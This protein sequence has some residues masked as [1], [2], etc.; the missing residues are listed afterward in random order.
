VRQGADGVEIDVRRTLDGH[1][2]LHH[3]DW[4]L[5]PYG[6]GVKVEDL[7]LAEVTKLDIGERWSPKFRGMRMPL[8]RDAMDFAK[9]NE[10]L[11]YL[12]IKTPGI[13]SAVMRMAREVGAHHLV[14]AAGPGVKIQK[15]ALP[16]IEGWNYLDGGEEDPD[17]LRRVVS[18]QTAEAW[19]AM[20]DDGRAFAEVL[21]RRPE[22]RP[23]QPFRRSALKIVPHRFTSAELLRRRIWSGRLR[24]TELRRIAEGGGDAA[25]R[26]DAWYALGRD[27]SPATRRY[28]EAVALRPDAPDPVKDPSGMPYFG[29][30]RRSAAAFGLVRSGE[31]DLRG[32]LGRIRA[33]GISFGPEAVALALAASGGPRAVP[34]LVEIAATGRP[35]EVNFVLAYCGYLDR[36]E[37]YVAALNRPGMARRNA[38]FALAQRSEETWEGVSAADLALISR[39]RRKAAVGDGSK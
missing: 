14:M 38:I 1:F 28:L 20:A 10:L 26:L 21:R 32:S 31:R 7:T 23:L 18:R 3:D 17:R 2:V 11:L 16:Q 12:D 39:W 13:E 35:S 8:L 33:S 4:V 36:P 37:I 19:Q 15:R 9:R 27:P 34:T 29:T 5:R 24:P 22:S 25:T 30:F 6:P